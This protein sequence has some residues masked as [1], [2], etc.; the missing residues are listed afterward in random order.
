AGE[1]TLPG[2]RVEA[3]ETPEVAVV[4]ELREETALEGRVVASLGV[5]TVAREGETYA[6]H[7]YL[8]RP[9]KPSRANAGVR[10]GDDAA[11]VRWVEAGEL[12]ALGVR[13]DAVAVIERGLAH[14]PGASRPPLRPLPA[15]TRSSHA[16]TWASRAATPFRP[17]R[18]WSTTGKRAACA[19]SSCSSRRG[20]RPFA[21]TSSAPS[22]SRSRR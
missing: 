15:P 3:G 13:S 8:V 4:R 9:A 6:I 2:G 19:V 20:R 1:W 21:S 12:A 10:A 11:D 5:V 22:A 16:C 14:A 7:E 17:A 18:S